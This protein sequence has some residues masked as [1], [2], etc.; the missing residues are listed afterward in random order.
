MQ[1]VLHRQST[2]QGAVQQRIL[3]AASELGQGAQGRVTLN[4]REGVKYQPLETEMQGRAAGRIDA[5]HGGD[6]G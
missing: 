4:L 5:A 2:N 6:N 3:C 1:A